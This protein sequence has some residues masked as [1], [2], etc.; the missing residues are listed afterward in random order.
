MPAES[1]QVDQWAREIVRLDARNKAGLKRKYEFRVR[2]ADAT[3]LIENHKLAEGRTAITRILALPASAANKSRRQTSPWP[4]A[5]WRKKT[6]RRA[7]AFSKKAL[8]ARP[9]RPSRQALVKS[10]ISQA[11]NGLKQQKTQKN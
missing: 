3:K 7:W 8:E 5:G 6:T 11:E 2:L 10:L 4:A 9:P 1:G